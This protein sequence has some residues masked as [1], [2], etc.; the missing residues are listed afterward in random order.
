MGQ[1]ADVVRS[2]YDAFGR[3]DIPAV[4][5]VLSDEVEWTVPKTV[6]HGGSFQGRDG[7]GR[8]FQGLGERWDG[9]AIDVEAIAQD[10]DLAIGLGR[11]Q[12]ELRGAGERS[13]GF[14]HVFTVRDGEVVRFREYVDLDAP[15]S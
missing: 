1:A 3:G 11:G 2:A 4:L 5:E 7:V 6:P 9:L 8:F 14:T 12:G 15:L 10:G 13:Y